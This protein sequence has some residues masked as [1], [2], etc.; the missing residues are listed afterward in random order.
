[1]KEL[2]LNGYVQYTGDIE[3]IKA[4]IKALD[5]V[6]LASAQPEPFG[7]VVIEAM[8]LARPVVA[9]A[10]GGSLEQVVDGVTGYLV[11][12]GDPVAMADG[13]E[14]ILV[15]ADRR[16]FF[17][18]NGHERYLEKFEFEQFYQL[19]LNLYEQV[20]TRGRSENQNPEVRPS[21]SKR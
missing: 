19:I 18:E 12:P 1:V 5:V 20:A 6:V 13:I 7:G 17:G 11:K 3:D 9:T 2:D 14:K 8:A 21:V 10:I 16:R 4:A 15:S